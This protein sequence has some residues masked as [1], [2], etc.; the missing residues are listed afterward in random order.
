PGLFGTEIGGGEMITS[1]SSPGE[2]VSGASTVTEASSTS[3]CGPPARLLEGTAWQEFLNAVVVVVIADAAGAASVTDPATRVAPIAAVATARPSP[4]RG[5][6]VMVVLVEEGI[7][8][9]VMASA[10]Q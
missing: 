7:R 8:V 2:T 3:F 4:R 1:N 9:R 5:V 6:R 10:L